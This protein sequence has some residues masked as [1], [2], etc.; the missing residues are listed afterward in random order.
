ETM[1]YLEA[2]YT[3]AVGTGAKAKGLA[4]RRSPYTVNQPMKFA[5]P[6]PSMLYVIPRTFSALNGSQDG[7]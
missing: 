2:E 5:L 3:C 4:M 7:H 1:P 6:L